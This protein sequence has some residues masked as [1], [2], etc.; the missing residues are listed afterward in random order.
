MGFQFHT[1]LVS[2]F[3]LLLLFS[4]SVSGRPT[5]FLQ[6]FKVTWADTHLR[7]IDGGRAIQ[8]VLDQSSGTIIFCLEKKN[9][10]LI[11]WI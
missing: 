11:P 10:F 5:T 1:S 8:L 7:Q 2:I 3:L 9:G 6:D 4:L